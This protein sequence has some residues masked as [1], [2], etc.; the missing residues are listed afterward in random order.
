VGWDVE[1]ADVQA[2]VTLWYGERD[3]VVGIEHGRWLH[4][5]LPTS[6]L[7]VHEGAGHHAVLMAHWADVLTDLA[8]PAG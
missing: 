4:A 7:V 3:R 8:C 2:P 6:R 1:L 5:R